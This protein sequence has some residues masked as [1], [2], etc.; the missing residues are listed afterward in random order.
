M[1]DIRF[2]PTD[3]LF[4]GASKDADLK[5]AHDDL[6]LLILHIW[7]HFWSGND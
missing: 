5:C 7:K 1:N 2:T 4:S 3:K 6:W